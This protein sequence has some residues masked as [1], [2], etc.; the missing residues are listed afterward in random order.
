MLHVKSC[1]V[2]HNSESVFCYFASA[3][4]SNQRRKWT[5]KDLYAI[6]SYSSLK[7]VSSVPLYPFTVMGFRSH[8]AQLISRW[9]SDHPLQIHLIRNPDFDG[10]LE[11][12]HSMYMQVSI[13]RSS[14]VFCF[15]CQDHVFRITHFK[16]ERS[17]YSP[18]CLQFICP[19]I[20][21]HMYKHLK[22]FTKSFQCQACIICRNINILLQNGKKGKW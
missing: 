18:S 7:K 19:I 20:T 11:T 6:C 22:L 4:N 2:K 16:I 17:F 5:R 12:V 15:V 9:N 14:T 21:Y 10:T 13:P 3:V 1:N 8:L